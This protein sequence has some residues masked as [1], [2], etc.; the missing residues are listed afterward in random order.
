MTKIEIKDLPRD[1]HIN[2]EEMRKVIGG[3]S[4]LYWNWYSQRTGSRAGIVPDGR[5]DGKVT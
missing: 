5:I 2:K 4:S 3:A 1:L